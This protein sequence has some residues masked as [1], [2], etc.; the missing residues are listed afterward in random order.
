[1]ILINKMKNMNNLIKYSISV[2][3]SSSIKFILFNIVYLRMI[4][5]ILEL[6][7]SKKI[8]LKYENDNF[9]KL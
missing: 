6:L 2:V 7:N 4:G 9:K 8:L 3:I 5:T 1:M